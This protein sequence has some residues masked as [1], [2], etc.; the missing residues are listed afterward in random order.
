[1]I[2][3]NLPQEEKDRL[4]AAYEAGF[5]AGSCGHAR[6]PDGMRLLI[7]NV[8]DDWFRRLEASRAA[9][10]ARQAE[11][12]PPDWLAAYAERVAAF[13]DSAPPEGWLE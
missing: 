12:A 5:A 3:D 7:A 10:D 13:G 9:Y 1:M 2:Y 11:Q 8:I 4:W 6:I